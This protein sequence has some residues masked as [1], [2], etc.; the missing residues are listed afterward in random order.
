M[1][2]IVTMEIKS[3][4]LVYFSLDLTYMFWFCDHL[5]ALRMVAEVCH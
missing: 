4:V 1:R 3:Y 2:L 5:A